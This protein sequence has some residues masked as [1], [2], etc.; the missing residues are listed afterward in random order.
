MI[1]TKQGL[2]K[3]EFDALKN[4]AIDLVPRLIG[5]M[6]TWN[7][8][9][10]I[11]ASIGS[12]ATG[13]IGD[14]VKKLLEEAESDKNIDERVLG[15][16]KTNQSF[17]KLVN[18]VAQKNPDFE[19]W[20]S[21]KKIFKHTLQS[22]VTEQERTSLYDLLDICTQLSGSE[23]RILAGAYQILITLDDTHKTQ[24]Q[25]S[26]W[27]DSIAKNIGFVAGEQVLRYEDNLVRQKLIAPRELAQ[28]GPL[29]TWH[30]GYG[31]N[32]HRLT[33]LGYELAKFLNK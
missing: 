2:I 27:A 32:G 23:I 7:S 33:S 11:F 9:E 13:F 1:K 30:P 17:I 18:F 4:M 22:N 6:S 10:Q 20:E 26:W 8:P 24:R 14:R 28:H 12:V 16:E 29:G 21:V 19:T 31:G 5:Q 15:S 25:V 3:K